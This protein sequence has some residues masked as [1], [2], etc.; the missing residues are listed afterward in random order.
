MAGPLLTAAQRTALLANGQRTAR[1]E[2]IDPKPVVKLFMP[3]G[4]GTWLLTELDP[5]QP[6]RAFGLCDTGLGSPELGYVCLVELAALRGRLGLP[7]ERDRHFVAD[8]LLYTYATEARCTG[9]IG[10]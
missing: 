1:G 4:P 6:T 7:L 2:D 9:R 3:D 5:D 8:R 10:A